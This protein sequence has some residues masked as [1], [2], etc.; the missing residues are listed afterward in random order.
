MHRGRNTASEAEEKEREREMQE[1][2]QARLGWLWIA[3]NTVFGE[4]NAT[5]D[6]IDKNPTELWGWSS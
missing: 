5:T 1:R 2:E 4:I 3:Q 6:E